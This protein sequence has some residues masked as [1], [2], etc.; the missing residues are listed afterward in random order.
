MSK[1]QYSVIW[2][3]SIILVLH[4]GFFVLF[5]FFK[6]ALSFC[7]DVMSP[8]FPT[9]LSVCPIIC[10]ADI[11]SLWFSRCESGC[12]AFTAGGWRLLASAMNNWFPPEPRHTVQKVFISRLHLWKI[13]P[14]IFLVA[15]LGL[16]IALLWRK[17]WGMRRMERG[18]RVSERGNVRT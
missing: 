12:F 4:I 15:S 7:S 5:C 11:A 1:E 18:E 14:L 16:V 17:G 13:L 2:H 9:Y 3:N 8:I 10:P 6:N